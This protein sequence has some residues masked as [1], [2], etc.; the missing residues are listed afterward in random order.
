MYKK[1]ISKNY[2]LLEKNIFNKFNTK[3]RN[4]NNAIHYLVKS[5]EL[6]I[7]NDLD[8]SVI[9]SQYCLLNNHIMFTKRPK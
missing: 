4:K 3:I 8:V 7:N 6:K 2:L 9:N 1:F 5:T